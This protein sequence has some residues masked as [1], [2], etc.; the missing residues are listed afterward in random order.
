MTDQ[1]A[2]RIAMWSGPRNISTAMMRAWENRSDTV[3]QDEPFYAHYLQATGIEHPLRDDVIASCETDW[4]RV[5]RQLTREPLPPGRTI[6]Y[7]KQMAHHILPRM[8]LDWMDSLVNCFLIREPREVIASYLK[9]RP[10][11]TLDDLGLKQQ[12]T[13][14][15]RARSIQGEDPPVIDARETLE[16]PRRMLG[17]LCE[18][19]GLPFFESML[20]WPAGPRDTDGVWAKRWYASVWTST[21]FAPYQPKVEAIPGELRDLLAAANELYAELHSRRLHG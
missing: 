3:V 15:Q 8:E 6:C 19:V 12:W 14:F 9:V 7:Q 21:G 5:A 2:I 11:V 18:R 20:S 13:L 4:R 10:D 1:S 16:N 17:L